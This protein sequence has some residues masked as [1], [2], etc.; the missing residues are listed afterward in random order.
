[1]HD[2]NANYH[3]LA[4]L[5]VCLCLLGVLAGLADMAL[6]GTPALPRHPVVLVGTVLAIGLLL[7]SQPQ[8]SAAAIHTAASFWHSPRSASFFAI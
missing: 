1:M 7:S 2:G 8:Y 3:S 5:G 6:S 4:R